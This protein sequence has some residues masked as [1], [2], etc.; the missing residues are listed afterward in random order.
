MQRFE[1]KPIPKIGDNVGKYGITTTHDYM[2][3]LMFCIGYAKGE[4]KPWACWR[5][6]IARG[7]GGLVECRTEREAFDLLVKRAE[8]RLRG[9]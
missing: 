5:W 1:H 2:D 3:G 4:A 6:D 7:H 9:K 8:V